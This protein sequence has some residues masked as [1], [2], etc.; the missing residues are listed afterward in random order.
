MLTYKQTVLRT[1]ILF[2]TIALCF[3]T[4][5][6]QQHKKR[7]TFKM[8]DGTPI[9]TK[10]TFRTANFILPTDD[11]GY[12][13]TGNKASTNTDTSEVVDLKGNIDYYE[14][15]YRQG[16][17]VRKID[18]QGKAEWERVFAGI[19]SDNS[20]CIQQTTDGGYILTGAKS[21]YFGVFN[22]TVNID[23]V[24]IKLSKK[25][26]IEWEKLLG[27][28]GTDFANYITPTKQ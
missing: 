23:A 7:S 12:I 24:I 17:W 4:V 18:K 6:S 26:K 8:P 10:A 2:S 28:S 15:N 9:R 14:L 27:G 20:N 16:I 13:I 3:S 21:H 1:A 22:S 5:M 19:S 11:G 25:G